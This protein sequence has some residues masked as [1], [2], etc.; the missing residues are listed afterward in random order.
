VLTQAPLEMYVTLVLGTGAAIALGLFISSLMPNTN[1]VIYVVLLVL[2]L[3]ILFA[4]VFFELP[5]ATRPLSYMTFSRW[6]ME[7]LGTTANLE[8][9]NGL[10]RTRFQPDPVTETARI[11]IE[12]PVPDFEPMSVVT[13]TRDTEVEIAPGVFRTVPI[14]VPQI[15]E[16]EPVTMTQ[17]LVQEFAVEPDPVD[18]FS[19]RDFQINYARSPAHLWRVWGVLAGFV[20]ALSVGTGAV[21]ELRDVW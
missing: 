14:S 5:Q 8:G 12:R 3:Q 1:T 2:F 10:T 4:G 6:V 15:V 20:L 21:L 9:L 18:I 16:N 17:F 19:R 7:G 13:V 11:P